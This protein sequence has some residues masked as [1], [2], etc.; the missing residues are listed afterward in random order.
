MT[1]TEK[2]ITRLRALHGQQGL[3]IAE[4]CR[5]MRLSPN[6]VLKY[7]HGSNDDSMPVSMPIS[8]VDAD[9]DVMDLQKELKMKKLKHEIN[10]IAPSEPSEIMLAPSLKKKLD[11][12]GMTSNDIF[13]VRPKAWVH[14]L[15]DV[16]KAA[17]KIYL[18]KYIKARAKAQKKNDD[19][20]F[21]TVKQY[22]NDQY[23][24]LINGKIDFNEYDETT[25]AILLEIEAEFSL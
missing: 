3:S 11:F 21:A 24:N 5:R 17:L 14:L 12:L 7:V 20:L 15:N 1:L 18:A 6:T 8:D 13:K 22:L 2:S 23:D 4:I 16:E 9:D 10:S 19:E 25:E